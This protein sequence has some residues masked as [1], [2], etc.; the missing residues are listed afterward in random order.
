MA[1]WQYPGVTV[2]VLYFFLAV[3]DVIVSRPYTQEAQARQEWARRYALG[4][5]R[6]VDKGRV[7]AGEN[8]SSA[9][10]YA[11]IN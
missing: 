8:E 10:D 1:I 3:N 2:K 6:D 9:H 7:Y 11:P 5:V 4:E